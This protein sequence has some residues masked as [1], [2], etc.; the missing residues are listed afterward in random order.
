MAY[1]KHLQQNNPE[2]FK[3]RQRENKLRQQN[4]EMSS[5]DAHKIITTQDL[6]F[7]QNQLSF[8]DIKNQKGLLRTMMIRIASTGEVMVC[9]VF[10]ENDAKAIEQIMSAL[11]ERFPSLTS[12]LYVVNLK[13]NDTIGDQD[14]VV[15]KGRDYINESMEGL[16]FRVNAKSF[17]QKG[18]RLLKSIKR[19]NNE[20]LRLINLGEFLV[21]CHET[22]RN[23]K[24]MYIETRKLFSATNRE[25]IK[26]CILAI[27]KIGAREIKNAEATIPI[28]KKDS[29]IGFEPSML[30]QCSEENLLWKIKQTK[31]ML[32]AELDYYRDGLNY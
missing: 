17:Y 9:M 13:V 4:P 6:L 2:E 26:K 23:A 21:R 11:S 24:L 22:A 16:Q 20:L 8:Y 28:V 10:G 32:T 19:K 7:E 1:W 27:E 31:Y 3:A 25:T 15:F 30:Y 18:V 14:V 29:S 5:Q 12:L